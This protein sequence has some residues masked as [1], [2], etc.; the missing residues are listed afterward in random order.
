MFLRLSVFVVVVSIFRFGLSADDVIT[1]F[2]REPSRG[3]E[4]LRR[5]RSWIRYSPIFPIWKRS[6]S[7]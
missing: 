7:I 2:P 4:G 5:G 6:S 3:S 1:A